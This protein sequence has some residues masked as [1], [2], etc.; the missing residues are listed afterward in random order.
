MTHRLKLYSELADWWPLLSA[1]EDYA[2]EADFFWQRFCDAGLPASPSLLELGCGGGNNASHLKRHFAS[3]TLTDLSP[4]MLAV[5]RA[6]NPECEHV[7]G[8]MR[9]LRLGRTFDAVLIHDAIDYMATREDLRRAMETSFVHCRPGGVALLVP[10]HVRETFQPSTDC[11]GWDGEGRGARYLEWTSEPAADD[12]AYDVD[13]AYLLREGGAAR[14]EH[15]RHR[16][17][18][19]PRAE[20]L[21]LLGAVGFEAEIVRDHYGRDVFVARKPQDRSPTNLGELD[22]I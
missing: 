1:P 8:D 11:G 9:D 21:R 3:V 5:S 20:W 7:A 13:Y 6:L 2:E 17:G 4:E 10:D 15:E 16:C 14:V 22:F 19:F 18:L 12:T